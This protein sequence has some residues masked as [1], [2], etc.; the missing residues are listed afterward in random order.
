MNGQSSARRGLILALAGFALL[1]CGDAVIKTIAGQ[2]PGTAVAALRYCIGAI[3]LGVILALREGRA[4]FR[5]TMPW[6][7]LGRGFSV[8]FATLC[9]FSAIYLMPLAEATAIVFIN[10]MLTALLS[11]L[12]L[13]EVTPKTTWVATAIAFIGVLIVL[14]PNVAEIGL[15]A[16]LP[17]LAAL[18]MSFLMIFNRMS[19]GSG[20]LLT[21][22]FYIAVIAAP[23][24]VLATILGHLSG[25]A[26]FVLTP[27]DLSVIARCTGVAFTATLS[28]ALIYLATTRASA[29][30]IA[31][32]VYVQLLIAT[33]IGIAY[34]GDWPDAMAAIGAAI[35]VSAG[36]Y[37]W[38]RGRPAR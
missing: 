16:F 12:I 27:P 17:L 20:S 28:H 9:F 18:G 26:T 21:T 11:A 7:Q 10:P 13:K 36:L 34:F 5:V 4:G 14:R 30:V 31:P 15:A 2:W 8:A 32:M 1:S 19:V 25:I 29:A 23:I 22:Q 6:I 35:I 38:Y 37:L 3:G 33:L 24:L